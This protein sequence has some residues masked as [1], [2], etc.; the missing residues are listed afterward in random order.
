[1]KENIRREK[2]KVFGWSLLLCMPH[3]DLNRN[4]WFVQCWKKC[5]PQYLIFS[6]WF[7]TKVL[8][9][10]W[11]MSWNINQWNNCEQDWEG[12]KRISSQAIFHDNI[13]IICV[14]TKW[15][16]KKEISIFWTEERIFRVRHKL[17]LFREI[18]VFVQMNL[19]LFIHFAFFV[20]NRRTMF[21]RRRNF[22]ILFFVIKIVNYG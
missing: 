9:L 8:F 15:F 12:F 7:M 14:C 10:T 4:R 19:I 17:R 18:K 20:N 21:W 1:M 2:R 5:V 13:V 22:W 16:C 3:M 11:K 6:K